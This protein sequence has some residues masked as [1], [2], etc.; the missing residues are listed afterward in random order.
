MIRYYDAHRCCYRFWSKYALDDFIGERLELSSMREQ[1][2]SA[3]NRELLFCFW[4]DV[5]G[6]IQVGTTEG[7]PSDVVIIDIFLKQRTE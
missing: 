6:R 1:F 4:I 5:L 2:P 3:Y 7:V